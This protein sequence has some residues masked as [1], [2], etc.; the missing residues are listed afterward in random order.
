MI[1]CRLQK[2]LSETGRELTNNLLAVVC[3]SNDFQF[4]GVSLLMLVEVFRDKSLICGLVTSDISRLSL[5][6]CGRNI[7]N[8]TV[9]LKRVTTGSGIAQAVS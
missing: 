9:D 4:G 8:T 6:I 7:W 3:Y 5:Q 2:R 1:F